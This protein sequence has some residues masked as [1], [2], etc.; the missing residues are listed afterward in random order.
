MLI[1]IAGIEGFGQLCD[2]AREHGLRVALEFVPFTGVPDLPAALRV[3]DKAARPNAGLVV[4]LGHHARS[5]GA[6]EDLRS[7]PPELV[8]TVQLVDGP[9]QA[10]DDLLDEAMFHRQLPGR[11]ALPLLADLRALADIGVRA[12]VGPEIFAPGD[13]SAQDVATELYAAT[14]AMLDE[15]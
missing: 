9:L 15:V 4:D 10:P 8:Y 6:P 5:G 1:R 12:A 13:R 14:V 3:L 2:E 7:V 11:G